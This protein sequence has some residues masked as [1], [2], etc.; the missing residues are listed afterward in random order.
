MQLSCISLMTLF[1]MVAL[2]GN[3]QNNIQVDPNESVGEKVFNDLSSATR[4]Y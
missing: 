1:I 3:G 4:E 2:L